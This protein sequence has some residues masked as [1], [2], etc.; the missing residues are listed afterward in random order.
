MYMRIYNEIAFIILAHSL[1]FT[2]SCT[3][4]LCRLSQFDLSDG[5]LSLGVRV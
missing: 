5:E 1:Q 3:S 4:K 2:S